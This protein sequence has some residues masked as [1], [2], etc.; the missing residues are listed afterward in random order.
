MNLKNDPGEVN[1]VSRK[2]GHFLLRY[3]LDATPEDK[4]AW[5]LWYARHPVR[6][7][8]HERGWTQATLCRRLGWKDNSI[9][10]MIRGADIRVS[11]LVRVAAALGVAA[12][13]LLHELMEWRDRNPEGKAAEEYLNQ[14]LSDLENIE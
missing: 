8:L 3:P 9:T 5:D 10:N 1:N 6:V 12:P 4:V 2:T 13:R 11:R 7:R 14:L